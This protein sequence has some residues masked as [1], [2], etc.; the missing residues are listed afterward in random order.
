RDLTHDD[1][2]DMAAAV[3]V[4]LDAALLDES[5]EALSPRLVVKVGYAFLAEDPFYRFERRVHASVAEARSL[6]DRRERNRDQIWG[7]ELRKAIREQGIRTVWQ[8]VVE[9]TSGLFHGFEAFARGPKDSM[10]EMP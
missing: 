3:K 5:F 4:R 2:A 6:H 9:L 1:L 7:A 8:P 10:F